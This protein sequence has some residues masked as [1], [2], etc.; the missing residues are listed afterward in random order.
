MER[1]REHDREHIGGLE[2]AGTDW[3]SRALHVDAIAINF[4]QNVNA[5]GQ[6]YCELSSALIVQIICLNILKIKIN[7]FLFYSNLFKRKNK[8]S[9]CLRYK[10]NKR[11]YK[12]Q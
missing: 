4:E 5:P 11:N 1:Q 7:S 10:N 3:K 8:Y 6:I 2:I 12:I 9:I